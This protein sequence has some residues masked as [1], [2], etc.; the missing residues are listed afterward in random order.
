M[1]IEQGR[2]GNCPTSPSL[3]FSTISSC[4]KKLKYCTVAIADGDAEFHSPRSPD[5]FT[6]GYFSAADSVE[7]RDSMSGRP[8]PRPAITELTPR[9]SAAVAAE[10]ATDDDVR[11]LA[12]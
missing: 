1:R 11:P 7:G 2:T 12:K 5:S 4:S 10:D 3:V 8:T 9:L 6:S